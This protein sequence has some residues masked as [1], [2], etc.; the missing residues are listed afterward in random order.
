VLDS[1]TSSQGNTL[2]LSGNSVSYQAQDVL[3]TDDFFSYRAQDPSGALSDSVVVT[4]IPSD[5]D[6]DGVVNALDNCPVFPNPNQSDSDSDQIGDLCDPDGTPGAPFESGRQLV[7]AEC[8]TCHL[9][10]VSG[11]PL[12]RDDAAWDA[13]IQAAGGQPEN[14]L[15][16]VLNGRGSMPS[17]SSAY[18]TQDLLQAI[19]Y[20]SGNE[21][22]GEVPPGTIVDTD[23]DGVA[24]DVDNCRT[25]PNADQLNS[26]DNSLGDACEPTAD[27]DG[28]GIPF[29]LDDDD[30]NAN[31]LLAS[32]PGSSNG[33]VFTSANSLVVGFVAE[34][35]S[36]LNGP[37]QTAVVL[38][39]A[40]F[41]EV[42]PFA[43]PGITVM[44]DTGHSSLMGIVNLTAQTES[45]QTQIII[46]LDSDLP[47]PF[48]PVIRLFNTNSGM[49][50]DFSIASLGRIA[51]APVT[52]SGCPVSTSANY[53]AGLSEGLQC[54]L[55]TVQD[56]SA[57]DADGVI[58]NQVELILNIARKALEDGSPVTVDLNPSKSGGGSAGP[59]I[60]FILLMTRLLLISGSLMRTRR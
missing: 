43:Y 41:A 1:A 5:Q 59:W 22:T 9:N 46:Q 42:V 13:R 7:E 19:R 24:D 51:S 34:V 25:V 11:A 44:T 56:G 28:D 58:N 20:L 55:L 3:T 12:F 48:N 21:D 23:L 54:L 2:Q 36:I 14:L 40:K 50:S 10:G 18:S 39:E 8:L 38:S 16:S 52:A 37:E 45:G 33:T 27:R 4:V 17:F 15:G 47:L 60:L 57:N 35:V 53:Q 30:G 6:G 49:W 32:Y 26:D 31:R 29:L